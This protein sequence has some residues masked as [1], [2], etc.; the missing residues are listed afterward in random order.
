MEFA[1]GAVADAELAIELGDQAEIDQAEL[2]G[3]FQAEE[4][5]LQGQ[6][7]G[8][9]KCNLSRGAQIRH[10]RQPQPHVGHEHTR[11]GGGQ[12]TILSIQNRRALYRLRVSHGANRE[13]RCN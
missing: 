8:F 1:D 2:Q 5:A 4:A 9:G 10:G 3:V 13:W 11:A 12:R 7:A 6:I